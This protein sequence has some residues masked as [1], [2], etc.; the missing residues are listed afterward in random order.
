MQAFEANVAVVQQ[1][2]DA[3][4]HFAKALKRG[5]EEREDGVSS[6]ELIE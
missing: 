3:P 4:I 1:T 6:C 2:S 5:V